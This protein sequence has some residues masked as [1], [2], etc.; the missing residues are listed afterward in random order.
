MS[1]LNDKKSISSQE[2]DEAQARLKVA[3]TAVAMAQ[4]RRQQL[5]ARIRQANEGVAAA[6][7]QRGF[8]EVRAPFAGLVTEKQAEPGMLAAPG[9][10]LFTVEQSGGLRLE[11]TIE[12]SMLPR[13]KVGQTVEVTLDALGKTA[14]GRLAELAPVVDPVSRTILV[15]IDLPALPGLRSG[16]FGRARFA[17]ADKS[18]LAIPAAAVRE[19]GQLR[20]VL[21]AEG[22]TARSRMVTLGAEREGHLEVLSGLAEGEKAVSPLPAGLVDGARV[23][24]RP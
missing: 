12:E 18:V 11:V 7:V 22:G 8:A 10:P 17:V 2:F 5:N 20:L 3:E 1:E 24:V 19:Q 23:E 14:S 21:V 6:G 16:V 4:S 9:A 15:K 13:L